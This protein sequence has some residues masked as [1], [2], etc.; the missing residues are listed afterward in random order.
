M[1]SLIYFLTILGSA[2]CGFGGAILWVAEGHY[3]SI[4]ATDK[5]KGFFNGTFWAFM[6]SS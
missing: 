2:I 4:C 5:N 6:Q 3:A 1:Y